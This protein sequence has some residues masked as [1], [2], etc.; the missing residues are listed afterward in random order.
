MRQRQFNYFFTKKI[1][2][3]T[4]GGDGG[5]DKLGDDG[6]E[7]DCDDESCCYCCCC[8]RCQ[9]RPGAREVVAVEAEWAKRNRPF[10]YWF[11]GDGS[12]TIH[13]LW[14]RQPKQQ[15]ASMPTSSFYQLN[16]FTSPK[17]VKIKPRKKA[18]MRNATQRKMRIAYY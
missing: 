4:L 7:D 5:G 13:R 14:R 3:Q 1:I 16:F 6:F 18:K 2:G 10:W 17:S 11:G 15:V 8:R 12:G 9:L